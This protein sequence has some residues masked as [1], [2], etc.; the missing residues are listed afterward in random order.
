M[1]PPDS[2]PMVSLDRFT[3][4]MRLSKTTMWRF[5]KRK[6][7]TTVNIYG[8]Q[9]I[10]RSEIA[11]FNARAGQFAKIINPRTARKAD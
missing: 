10:S 9:Y 8:R 11:K 6:M 7:L 5:R 2:E 3:E 1:N 4:Q